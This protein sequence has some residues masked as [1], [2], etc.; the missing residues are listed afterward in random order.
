[1]E[2]N[3]AFSSWI[4]C[5][6]FLLEYSPSRE[7]HTVASAV[8]FDLSFAFREDRVEAKDVSEIR[9]IHHL[10]LGWALN[11]YRGPIKTSLHMMW[12]RKL[13]I[14]VGFQQP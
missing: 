14:Q 2:Y 12:F 11:K 9:K 8:Q 1:M 5:F 10:A 6:H 4:S 7:P 3:D 13:E